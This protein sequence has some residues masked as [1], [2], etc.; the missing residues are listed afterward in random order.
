MEKSAPS[1]WIKYW[2]YTENMILNIISLIISIL[3]QLPHLTLN[4]LAVYIKGILTNFKTK[5]QKYLP[6]R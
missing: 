1:H 4:I 2:P 3:P 5:S 6:T